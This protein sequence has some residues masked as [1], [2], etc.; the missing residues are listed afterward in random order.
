MATYFLSKNYVAASLL[1]AK[2][3]F[4]KERFITFSELNQFD[5]Y[6][7]QEFNRRDLDV[8]INSDGLSREDFEHIGDV[9]IPSSGCCFNLDRLP[10]SV[11]YVLKDKELI[12]KFFI[13]L[14]SEKLKTLENVCAATRKLQK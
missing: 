3:D 10:V 1:E 11:S 4:Y 5:Y 8:V 6:I 7:Q 13:D 2:Y 14:E 9:I 12:A